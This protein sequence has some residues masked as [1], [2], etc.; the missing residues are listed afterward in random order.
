MFVELIEQLARGATVITANRRLAAAIRRAYDLASSQQRRSAW[1]AADVL[2]WNAWLERAF[3]DGLTRGAV[4]Q[5]LISHWQARALWHRVITQGPEAQ[6]LLQVDTAALAAL[7]AWELV[8]A[9]RLLPSL[10]RHP[11]TEEARAF[12]RWAHAYDAACSRGEFTDRARLPDLLSDLALAG[13]LPLSGR[14]MVYGFDALTPQQEALLDAVRSQG[15]SVE[16]LTASG[17]EAPATVLR[18]AAPADEIRAAAAWARTRISADP[19]ARVGIVVPDLTRLRAA[20]ARI[21]DEVLLPDSVLHPGR[22]PVR[23]WN[24]S[25]GVPLS[26]WP[27]VHAAL[28]ILELA[29]GSLSVHRIGLLLRS[30]FVGGAESE[31]AARA[32]L[33]ARLRRAGDS[34]VTL[35][36]LIYFAGVESQSGRCPLLSRRLNTLRDRVREL[37]ASA[38]PASA[39]GPALQS[40]LS[41]V[42]W[43]GERELNS[44]EYQSMQK[45]RELVAGLAHLDL[46]LAPVTLPAAVSALRRLVGEELFQPETPEVPIQVLGTLE[47]A[48]L[49]FDHLMVLGLVDD[50]W[51]RPARP[52]PLLPVE[53]QRSRGLP[54]SSAEWELAFA[55]R[56]QAGWR[57]SA[58]EVVFSFYETDGELA[59]TASPLLAGFPK[60]T[61]DQLA[62][63]P[64]PDWRTAAHAAAD[65]ERIAD[66]QA[67]ALPEGVA[68][69]GGARVIQDQAACP[70]R[71]FAVHR[72]TAVSL[73]QPHEGLDARER[74]SLL[75]G[76]MAALWSELQT[77]ATLRAVSSE[78]IAAVVGRSVDT[79]LARLHPKR[80]S[81]LRTR[82][83]ELERERLVALLHEWLQVERE[84][85]PFE[86]VSTEQAGSVTVGGLILQLRLDRVDRLARGGELLIDYKTGT[87]AVVAW[88]GDR[89]EE[90]QLPLYGLARPEAPAAVAFALV[91]RGHCALLG[92]AGHAGASEG[93]KPLA[94][95]EYA[96]RFP[97]WPALLAAWR[98]TLE[99][100]AQ[101]FRSGAAVV[102]PKRRPP[103]CR[104][105]DLSTLCRVSELVD[106]GSPAP[107]ED[108]RDD[109]RA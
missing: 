99:R 44:E 89:P 3:R 58:A 8:H 2:P 84:R 54:A 56:A 101:A 25:L 76:A 68:L 21:F 97:T 75:H 47:S 57:R 17:G 59:L 102:D 1:T 39:W 10:H 69:R 30:P 85:E 51:P 87:N 4:R 79:A 66:W 81:S 40:L 15:V 83:L 29:C 38:Q 71:A 73:E 55:R 78:R 52:N 106:R 82:F 72:L 98:L 31:R 90:P 46:V 41:A 16:V 74:G 7:E 93:V 19:R 92:L 32:Q 12:L 14:V 28:L 77:L 23:P 103:A 96:E 33:D 91:R 109:L 9:W 88:M 105:C 70:F 48:H 107:L 18:H 100:L 37:T 95:S 35:E 42:Q 24:M 34:R 50:A 108:A 60:A 104:H 27:L 22:S 20:I 26:D 63:A 13:S 94:Q 5:L 11:D 67:G 49:P 36:T 53:L 45:W 64:V 61:L 6:G 62:V 80:T 43:P 65:V 86:V